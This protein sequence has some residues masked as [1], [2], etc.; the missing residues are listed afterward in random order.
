[1]NR[2]QILMTGAVALSI[3]AGL[4]AYNPFSGPG[5][6]AQ[7]AQASTDL[8]VA[9]GTLTAQQWQRLGIRTQ[10]VDA[11]VD[12]PLGTVPAVVTLPPEAQVA[13]TA[14]FD[15]AILRVYVI[16][17]EMVGAGQPLATVRSREPLQYGAELARAQ[18][19]L[20]LA[21]ATA[22]RTNARREMKRFPGWTH[23]QPPISI[24][25]TSRLDY[26]SAFFNTE[27]TTTMLS[28]L[29]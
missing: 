27:H 8:R 25:S 4:L 10:T 24:Y 7:P 20:G 6:A 26:L 21:Q 2:Q 11:S 17:G 22:A 3:A 9:P 29:R 28:H 18:A 13:V 12:V 16:Q 1:M 15:G 19:R 23:A 5:D 14:P